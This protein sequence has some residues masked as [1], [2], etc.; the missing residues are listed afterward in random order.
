MS[1]PEYIY[2]AS[3]FLI[4]LPVAWFAKSRVAAIVLGA[5]V[6]GQFT[7]LGGLP[8]PQTQLAIYL[9]AFVAA[10]KFHRSGVGVFAAVLFVPLALVSACDWLHWMKP[11]EAWWSVYWI[12]LTQ[13]MSLPFTIDWKA[14]LRR[15]H[16]RNKEGGGMG[17]LR[18]IY[19]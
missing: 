19:E 4:A 7:Y 6:I 10:W 9:V 15:R 2:Y 5:W 13:V 18:M 11:N 16:S 12:A 14:V 3:M 1:H 17:M 8:E